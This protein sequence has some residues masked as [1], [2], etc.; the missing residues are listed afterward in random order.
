[1]LRISAHV[2]LLAAI[3]LAAAG[4]LSA[5]R[6]SVAHDTPAA[7]TV[8]INAQI[9]DGTGKP[10]RKASVRISGDRIVRIGNFRPDRGE[11]I[12][13]A[14]GLVLAPG[15]IDIHNHSTE[16]LDTDPPAE[17]QI[18]QGI[19]TVI[20]GAD[21]DSPWPIGAWLDAH[22]KNPAAVNVGMLVG[23][24]TIREEIMGKDFKRVAT[25]D[26]IANMSVL[27]DQAMRAGALG[28]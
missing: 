16:G 7:G 10:L 12:I 25:G 20:L 14:K 23:H 18:A 21:G 24:A 22:R 3:A 28:L 17:T 1:M 2:R 19:T 15:F 11:S 8:F 6:S 13:D 27:V 4:I 5:V 9:A 26:E